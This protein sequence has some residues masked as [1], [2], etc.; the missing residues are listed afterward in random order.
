MST[1]DFTGKESSPHRSSGSYCGPWSSTKC[2]DDIFS[3]LSVF[4]TFSV[5]ARL[6]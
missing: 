5:V 4:M 3:V 1:A 2:K 6:R